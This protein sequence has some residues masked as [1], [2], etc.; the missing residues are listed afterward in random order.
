MYN[1]GQKERFI[2]DFTVKISYRNQALKLFNRLEPYEEQWGADV[3]TMN[4]ET[5]EPVVL[6]MLGTRVRSGCLPSAILHGYA[7]WCL[8]NGIEG[9]TNALLEIDDDGVKRMRRRTVR[10]PRH[11][12]AWLD[13]LF[14]RE[15]AET[16]DNYLRAFCWMVYAGLEQEDA[17]LVRKSDV[18]FVSAVIRFGGLEYPIYREAVPSLRNCIELTG[19]RH[20]HPL[21]RENTTIERIPGDTLIRSST[22]IGLAS[23]RVYISDHAADAVKNGRTDIRMSAQN[24]RLSGIFYRMYEDEQAGFPPDFLE[25]PEL[26]LKE[27]QFNVSSGRNTQQAKQRAAANFYRADYEDWKQTLR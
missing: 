3:V 15:D 16:I 5:V 13:A 8:D 21:R 1:A 18:D 23:I 26:K 19:F 7:R 20:R 6:S 25:R 17:L 22:E 10:N 2:K 4:R 11:M 27:R 24:I 14:D 9:A 12:Q